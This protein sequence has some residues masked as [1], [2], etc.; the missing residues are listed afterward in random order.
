MPAIL[1]QSSNYSILS[2][3]LAL[4]TK[5]FGSKQ[6]EPQWV[7]TS[8]EAN[9]TRK[10]FKQDTKVWLL[11]SKNIDDTYKCHAKPKENNDLIV[12]HHWVSLE[13]IELAL[14]QVGSN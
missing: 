11:G 12:W 9:S 5:Y 13:I 4:D 10:S 8:K 1:N 14:E 6:V 2:Q 7:G 3:K